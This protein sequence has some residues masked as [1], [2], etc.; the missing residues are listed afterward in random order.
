MLGDSNR[1]NDGDSDGDSNGNNKNYGVASVL[2]DINNDE[3]NHPSSNSY[4][5]SILVVGCMVM[6]GAVVVM[7]KHHQRK[8]HREGYTKIKKERTTEP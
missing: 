5:I 4:D 1:N 7:L 6:I 3:H 8:Y 2:G